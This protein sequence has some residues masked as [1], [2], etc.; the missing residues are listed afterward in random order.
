MR[1]FVYTSPILFNSN[2]SILF[3]FN[4]AL[5]NWSHDEV[6]SK[7]HQYFSTHLGWYAL[8]C[9]HWS[10]KSCFLFPDVADREVFYDSYNV[11]SGIAACHVTQTWSAA[12]GE[13]QLAVTLLPHG[14]S[15]MFRARI[16]YFWA[17]LWWGSYLDSSVNL[18]LTVISCL[19]DFTREAR[20]LLS[21]Y[22]LVWGSFMLLKHPRTNPC[23]NHCPY[24][25]IFQSF[26]RFL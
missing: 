18:S 9:I 21:P 10:F 22:F 25:F 5:C 15:I 24:V 6:C 11:G 12:L 16:L 8:L 26:L 20:K 17:F 19:S 4:Y 2:R 14:K 7:F 23:F 1:N 13:P 3:S